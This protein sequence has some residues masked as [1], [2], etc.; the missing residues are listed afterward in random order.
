MRDQ[1]VNVSS[2]AVMNCIPVYDCYVLDS[3][4]LLHRL[5]W[6]KGDTNDAMVK[7][8]A[9]FTEK[10]QWCSMITNT[11]LLSK[12]SPPETRTKI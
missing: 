3:G 9:D 8:Y 11:V 5:P 12:V 1:D 10:Q 4:P 7:S 6:K 2:E